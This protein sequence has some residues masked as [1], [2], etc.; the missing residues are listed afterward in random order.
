MKKTEFAVPEEDNNPPYITNI[1]GRVRQSLY[2]KL[3]EETMHFS[4]HE[5]T[6]YKA[7]FLKEIDLKFQSRFEELFQIRKRYKEYIIEKN[8]KVS[9][10]KLMDN[11]NIVNNNGNTSSH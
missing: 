9:T 7:Q 5:R 6:K 11:I 3:V 4:E 2:N 1:Y 10:L 8:F